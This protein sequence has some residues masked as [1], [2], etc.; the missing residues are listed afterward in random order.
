[1]VVLRSKFYTDFLTC[2]QVLNIMV[3][4]GFMFNY[5]LRVNLTIAIVDMV[6]SNTTNNTSTNSTKS[7]IDETRFN[8]NPEQ[9]NAVLGSFFWGYVLTELPGGRMAE[10]VGARKI[11]GGGMLMASI[12][13]ILTPA[14][15]YLNYYVILIL[16]AVL[17]FFLGATW[18]A[19]Q[20][21]AAKWI[22]PMERCVPSIGAA[23]E[24]KSFLSSSKFIANMMASS[25]GAAITM[26]VCGY[27]IST[28]GWASV[29]YV[30]GVIGIVWS[31]LWFCLIYD[32][33][34]EHPRISEE[35]REDIE[36]KI[37]DGEGGKNSKPS[38]VPWKRIFLSLPVWAIII[39]H[40]CS[41][42]GY[43]TVVNQ[44]P[45]YMKNVLHFNIKKN[46]LLSS[47]PYLAK[48]IMAIIASYFADRLRKSGK[49]ST[50][51]TRKVFT[52]FAIMIPGCLMAVQAIWGM[53]ATLS[54]AVFTISLFFNGA[55]TAGYLANALDIAPNFSGTIFGLANT[56]SSFGGWLS[57]KI[58]AVLTAEE[59]T[60]AT[61]KYV[62]WILV[63]T[64]VFGALFYLLFGS[65]K[66][67]KWNNPDEAY[68]QDGKELQP[69]KSKPEIEKEREIN[70]IA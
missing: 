40:G 64:Y 39:T 69:L 35:E 32:S 12:L 46:G 51:A 47:L 38:Y 61:W 67:Q 30:T 33:P 6:E 70:N 25:L 8:W 49:L 68:G 4:L 15:A 53:D 37:A 65:G 34:A 16:R 62:F 24:K 23:L 41:V 44:L 45:T 59:S 20:P 57:T 17:G 5:M 21:M 2:R 66:L 48:Y 36:A 11:F 19:I 60:F 22:P 50:T 29:F 56:L 42:F 28:V 3:I 63:F 26:P 58:V 14:A 1:M 18:P 52:T 13:T 10:I 7:R 43:F 31:I 9:Y 54:V 27:L 55:V